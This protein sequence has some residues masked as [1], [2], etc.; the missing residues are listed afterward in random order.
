[1]L[2]ETDEILNRAIQ[3]KAQ[4]SIISIN[5]KTIPM[6]VETLCVH[7]DNEQAVNMIQSL[8]QCLAP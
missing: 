5:G 3:L 8:K 4:G 6:E 7:G 1:M 2:I